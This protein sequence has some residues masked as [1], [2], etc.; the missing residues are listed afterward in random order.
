MMILSL[1]SDDVCVNGF[2]T[3]GIKGMC[4]FRR[5]MHSTS[6]SFKDLLRSV[7]LLPLE[8]IPLFCRPGTH[9]QNS[10]SN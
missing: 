3:V 1:K 6:V 7:G 4:I 2:A 5:R 10:V 9:H 8:R